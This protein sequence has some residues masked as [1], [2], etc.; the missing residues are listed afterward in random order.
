MY[1]ARRRL[2]S[3][4]SMSGVCCAAAEKVSF[5]DRAQG[6]LASITLVIRLSALMLHFSKSAKIPAFVSIN[7][8]YLTYY[9]IIQ[10][11]NAEYC[12]KSLL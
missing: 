8:T 4:I 2:L 3:K 10:V 12:T 9:N 1:N 7:Y 6:S 11:E 5:S